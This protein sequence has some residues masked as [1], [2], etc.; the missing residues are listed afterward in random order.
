MDGF[1]REEREERHDKRDGGREGR[2]VDARA[3][4]DGHETHADADADGGEGEVAGDLH[5]AE[6]TCDG[7]HRRAQENKR[8]CVVDKPAPPPRGP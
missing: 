4:P 8:G 1:G 7:G 6:R 5:E 3:G 2:L